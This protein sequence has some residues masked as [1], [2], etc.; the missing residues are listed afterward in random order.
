MNELM[1]RH[2]T[3]R[4]SC[5]PVFPLFH[6]SFL[7][8]DYHFRR[9]KC[10]RIGNL[11]GRGPTDSAPPSTFRKGVGFSREIGNFELSTTNS[12]PVVA[13]APS[14]VERQAPFRLYT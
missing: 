12:P 11:R 2:I 5:I 4:L 7:H 14:T 3:F 10:Y 6:L 8:G 9:L 13:G 1:R